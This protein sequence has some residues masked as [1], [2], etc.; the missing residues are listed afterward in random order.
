MFNKKHFIIENIPDLTGKLPSSQEARTHHAR[1]VTLEYSY[2][3]F[4]NLKNC[5]KSAENFLSK[6]LPLHIL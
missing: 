4:N 6:D 5:K 2:L 1:E 3:D